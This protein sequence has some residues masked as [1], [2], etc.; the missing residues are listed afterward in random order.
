M[1][2]PLVASECRTQQPRRA[3]GRDGQQYI[4]HEEDELGKVRHWTCRHCLAPGGK[5]EPGNPEQD[6]T[7]RLTNWS[8]CSGKQSAKS[9]ERLRSEQTFGSIVA[10]WLR[11]EQGQPVR[12]P[13]GDG[14]RLK[15]SE[16]SLAI[17]IESLKH[18]RSVTRLR[19]DTGTG[20][21]QNLAVRCLEQAGAGSSTPKRTISSQRVQPAGKPPRKDPRFDPHK[22]RPTAAATARNEPISVSNCAG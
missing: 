8:R 17:G 7:E 11:E 10:P 12:A 5:V 14:R 21:C 18:H 13:L 22:L 20:H 1:R 15:L 16:Q 3:T 19:T 2:V 9:V 6:R 4:R